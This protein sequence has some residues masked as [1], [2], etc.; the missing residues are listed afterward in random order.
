MDAHTY[1]FQWQC[2]IVDEAHR[3]KNPSSVLYSSLQQVSGI[4]ACVCV[5]AC[6]RVCVLACVCARVCVYM[7]A[8]VCMCV[9]VL[10]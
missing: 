8:C 9:C 5:C 6:V 4:C 3:L 1:R 10:V 7:R 2:L